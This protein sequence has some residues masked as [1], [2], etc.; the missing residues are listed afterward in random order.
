MKG[1]KFRHWLSKKLP[2]RIEDPL[3]ILESVKR[4]EPEAIEEMI[5]G[6]MGLVTGLVARY[7]RANRSDELVSAAFYGLVNAVNRIA[8]GHLNHDYPNPTA[9]IATFVHG[10]IR[11]TLS[12]RSVSVKTVQ[13]PGIL[14]PKG[15]RSRRAAVAGDRMDEFIGAYPD[16]TLDVEERINALVN[17]KTDERIIE[18]LRLGYDG[19]GI[20][21]KLNLHRSSVSRR[22]NRIR[23]IYR[24]LEN[25]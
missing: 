21:K 25:E 16:T 14:L 20:G 15:R 24:E 4:G 3:L 2:K 18:L 10:E 19:M 7:N 11:R 1:F 23:K 12:E 6:H 9:Y 5:L 8:S 17:D 22:V 13:L